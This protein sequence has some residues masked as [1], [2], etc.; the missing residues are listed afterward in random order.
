M[1]V[2]S[3]YEGKILDDKYEEHSTLI[4]DKAELLKKTPKYYGISKDIPR[5]IRYS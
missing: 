5:K 4:R 2:K 1:N 3:D